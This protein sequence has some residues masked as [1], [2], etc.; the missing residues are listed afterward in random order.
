MPTRCLYVVLV[1][2]AT[3]ADVVLSHAPITWPDPRHFKISLDRDT[4]RR[5]TATWQVE[6][7]CH[8]NKLLKINVF[9]TGSDGRKINPEYSYSEDNFKIIKLRNQSTKY[10]ITG[11]VRTL[12]DPREITANLTVVTGVCYKK[13]A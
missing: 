12:F 2:L 8:Q 6:E 3:I 11:T 9:A 7:Y 4:G 13:L 1:A 5:V 10:V